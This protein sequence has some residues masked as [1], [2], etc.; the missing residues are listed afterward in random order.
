MNRY[1]LVETTLYNASYLIGLHKFYQ[2]IRLFAVENYKR[3][4]PFDSVYSR[5]NVGRLLF[6]HYGVLILN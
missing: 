3:G 1:I 4:L 2:N 6:T 5:M